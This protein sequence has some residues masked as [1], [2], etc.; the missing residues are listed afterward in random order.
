MP[1]ETTYDETALLAM[2]AQDSEYAFQL[3]F[4]TYRNRIYGI[5]LSY[6]KESILAEEA[7]QEVFLKLWLKRKE[8]SDTK[9]LQAWLFTVA[10]NHLLNQ[11]NKIAREW[12]A[13]QGLA[14]QSA[15]S[16]DTA[17]HKLLDSEYKKLLTL[18]IGQLS[19]RQQEVYRL[20][21][22]QSLTYEQ[23]AVQLSMS[24]LTVK[25]HLSRAMESIRSF[26]KQHGELFLVLL[27][28]QKK[29]F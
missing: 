13:R 20:A 6:L 7:V 1:F 16:E 15:A 26:L 10:K 22:E 21:K 4:D 11:V 9:S 25:T 23:I 27:M 5:S 2:L 3:V 12:K 24:P 18:A 17:S 28:M 29:I 8:L 19:E 14:N